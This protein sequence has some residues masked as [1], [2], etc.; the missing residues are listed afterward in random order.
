M[1]IKKATDL[2]G[3]A[4]WRTARCGDAGA[5]IIALP[6]A[7]RGDHG[8]IDQITR[9]GGKSRQV[10][11]AARCGCQARLNRLIGKQDCA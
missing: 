6:A 11:Q 3:Q 2:I 9:H 7:L 5:V 10:I 1:Y 8:S 4:D